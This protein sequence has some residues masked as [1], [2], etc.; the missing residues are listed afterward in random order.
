[1]AINVEPTGYAIQTTRVTLRVIEPNEEEEWNA[2]M[3]MEHP[4]GNGQFPGLRIKYVAEHRGQAV[5]LLCFSG[6]AYHLADRDRWIGWTPE[7]ATK[8]RHFVVQNSRFLIVVKGQRHN[9]AS[10]VLSLCAKRLPSDWRDRFGFAPELLETFVDPAHFRG[11]CYHAAGWT[12]V[13]HTRGFSRDGREFYAEDSSTKDIWM[14]ALRPDARERLRAAELPDELR[15][16]EKELPA[17]QVAVRLG[18]DGLR[19]LFTVLRQL[20]DTRG[21]QGRRYPLACCLSIM[22]CAVMAGCKGLR[23]CAEFAATLSQHQLASLRA[24]RSPRTEKCVP[25]CY[26]TLHRAICSVDA[27]EFE[28]T[29]TGWFRDEGIQPEAIAL[30]GKTLRATIQNEDGGAHVVSAVSHRGT[31]FFSIKNSLPGKA[32]K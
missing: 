21:T 17:K 9:L 18:A 3:D 23:E 26:T 32:R 12:Q 15:A 29:V 7:Q 31:P 5:A 16:F 14:K 8:R 19:S 22:V 20:K 27:T 13:G 6:S 10:R 11:T 25:P 28:Q 24:W 1:M 4:L 30:D 2:Q